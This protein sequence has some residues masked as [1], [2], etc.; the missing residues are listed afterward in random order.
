MCMCCSGDASESAGRRGSRIGDLAIPAQ[1]TRGPRSRTCCR[2]NRT[3]LCT[4]SSHVSSST[5][6]YRRDRRG[7]S[8]FCRHRQTNL[9]SSRPIPTSVCHLLLVRATR[10]CIGSPPRQQQQQQRVSLPLAA[11]AA[12]ATTATTQRSDETLHYYQPPD[13]LYPYIVIVII[14]CYY[15]YHLRRDLVQYVTLLLVFFLRD[16]SRA[17]LPILFFFFFFFFFFKKLKNR[18]TNVYFKKK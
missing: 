3:H 13:L 5:A 15:I 9:G 1:V 8:A 18:S 6:G 2:N 11:A 10:I 14:H 16:K 12:T 17:R 7:T 4:N